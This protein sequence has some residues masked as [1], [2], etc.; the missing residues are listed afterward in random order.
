MK[1]LITQDEHNNCS[2]EVTLKVPATSTP[3]SEGNDQVVI[4]EDITEGGA[5]DKSFEDPIQTEEAISAALDEF[6]EKVWYVRHKRFMRRLEQGQEACDPEILKTA[7]AAAKRIRAKYGEKNLSF[8]DF[9]WGMLNGKLSAL[10]WV[11]GNE[12]DMLDT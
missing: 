6:Y 11:L 3:E 4:A 8:D 12:W 9:E 5:D 2:Y 10:R 7:K 1:T